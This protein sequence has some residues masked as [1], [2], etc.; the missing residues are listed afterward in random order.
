MAKNKTIPTNA[1][2]KDFVS[3][4]A[5]ETRRVD[6]LVLIE[7]FKSI[8]DCKPKMWGPSIIGFGKYHYQ[9]ASGHEGDAPLAAFSPRKDSLVIYMAPEFDQREDLLQKLGKHRSSKS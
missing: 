7:L 4:V 2:V 5:N 9:Y 8:T 6:S 1:S 3:N